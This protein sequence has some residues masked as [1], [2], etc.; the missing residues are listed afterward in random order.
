MQK[1]LLNS[2]TYSEEQVKEAF[3]Q[4]QT[5]RKILGSALQKEIRAIQNS[6]KNEDMYAKSGW[7]ALMADRLGQIKAIERTLKCLEDN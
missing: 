1:K 5:F 3:H 2:S 6:L 4:A 7:S